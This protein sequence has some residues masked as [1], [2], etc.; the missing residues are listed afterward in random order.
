MKVSII[1]PAWNSEATIKDT[2]KSVDMQTYKDIEHLVIDGQSTDRTA[3]IVSDFGSDKVRIVSEKDQGIYDA[4]NKG[5]GM[6]NG[7]IVGILNSDDMFNDEYTVEKVV[8]AFQEQCVDCV[9]GDII[10]VDS[11]D[12]EKAIRYWKSSPFF[13][14]A[15]YKG[16]HPPHPTFFVRKNVYEKYGVFRSD[17]TVSADFELMLRF[18][19]KEKLSSFYIESVLVKMRMGGESNSSIRNIVKGNMNCMKAFKLNGLRIPLFYPI[20]RL[21]PKVKQFFNR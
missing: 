19:E 6:V 17:L 2:L 4:M 15:F 14:G 10:Y 18:L 11:I 5:I 8:K 13:P 12:T 20:V 1:T 16:W 3:D 9:Y 7:D 21:L